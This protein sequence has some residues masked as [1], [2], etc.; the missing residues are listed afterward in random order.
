MTVERGAQLDSSFIHNDPQTAGVSGTD[1]PRAQASDDEVPL[2]TVSEDD[3]ASE[4]TEPSASE[5]QLQEAVTE[6]E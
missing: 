3:A 4:A 6:Q 2:V 5:E 1:P